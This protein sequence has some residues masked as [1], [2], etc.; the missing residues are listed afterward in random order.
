[1]TGGMSEELWASYGYSLSA[2]VKSVRT[3]RG[4]SQNRL[5]EL[6]GLSRSLVS[7]LERN[8]Y[9]SAKVADPTLSTIY[10]L[11]QALQVP[12]AVLLPAAGEQPRRVCG[13]RLDAGKEDV[14]LDVLWPTRPEDTLPFAE[15][16]SA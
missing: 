9:G 3:M 14:M 11:A 8:S 7:N 15:Q 1:M 10:R 4:I 16:P 13:E 5:A 6:S 2:R 12:P